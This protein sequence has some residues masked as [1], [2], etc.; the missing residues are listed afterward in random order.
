MAKRFQFRLDPLL[1]IKS[2]KVKEAKE[3]LIQIVGLRVRK[4]EEIE[5]HLNYYS[6]LF[7]SKNGTISAHELQTLFFHKIFVDD[8][9]KKLGKE[10]QQL[11]EIEELKRKTL[12]EAMKDEKILEK[13][14]EKK[15]ITYNQELNKEET[16]TLDEIAIKQHI[17]KS[18]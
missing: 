10:K 13:L 12:T 7:K 9:I 5:Q 8:N 4:E 17:N 2:F 11:L 14:K 6:S 3:N 1:S 18:Q 16:K 15:I